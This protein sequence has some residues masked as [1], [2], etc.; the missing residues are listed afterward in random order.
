M[1]PSARY[2]LAVALL[3]CCC[4]RIESRGSLKEPLRQAI[5]RQASIAA[6]ATTEGAPASPKLP[7][8]ISPG[9]GSDRCTTIAVGPK[10]RRRTWNDGLMASLSLV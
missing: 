8:K 5:R 9:P 10:V 2:L 4:G 7:A 6:T 1:A 3:A